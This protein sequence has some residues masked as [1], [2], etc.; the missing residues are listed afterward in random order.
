MHDKETCQ[1]RKMWVKY[2]ELYVDFFPLIYIHFLAH[3]F[4]HIWTGF[5]FFNHLNHRAEGLGGGEGQ[6]EGLM[7]ASVI[8]KSSWLEAL[9][10]YRSR[11]VCLSRK[12]PRISHT[13][14][15]IR[16]PE[17]SRNCYRLYMTMNFFTVSSTHLLCT[18]SWLHPVFRFL[19]LKNLKSIAQKVAIFREWNNFH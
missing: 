7:S 10:N 8:W 6:E 19:N 15:F 11:V 16:H 4:H 14:P 3:V 18:T 5:F 1:L 17:S 13:L 12:L 9:I 2:K